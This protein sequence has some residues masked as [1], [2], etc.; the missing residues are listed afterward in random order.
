MV[1]GMVTIIMI[2]LQFQQWEFT[3]MDDIEMEK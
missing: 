1:S 3:H 2:L